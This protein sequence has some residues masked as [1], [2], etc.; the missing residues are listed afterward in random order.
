AGVLRPGDR[1]VIG[2]GHEVGVALITGRARTARG[3]VARKPRQTAALD[4]RA[5]GTLARVSAAALRVVGQ[6]EH[7]A[8]FRR[9]VRTAG[10]ADRIAPSRPVDHWAGRT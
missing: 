3:P 8:A 9:G 5:P 1:H 10:R 4:A 2:P 7:P 6:R